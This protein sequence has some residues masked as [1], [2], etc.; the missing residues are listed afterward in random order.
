M[1][2]PG[3]DRSHLGETDR[4]T[5]RNLLKAAGAGA[6]IVPAGLGLAACGGPTTTRTLAGRPRRGGTLNV[7]LTGG[8]A[9]DTVNAGAVV[10]NPDNCRAYQL[11]N[12]PAT[13]DTN[14]QIVNVLVEEFT[15]NSDATIWTMRLRPDVIFHN[16]KSLTA[17]DLIYTL[18]RVAN[19]KAP[20]PGA[21]TLA[22]CDIANMKKLDKLTV[23]LPCKAPYAT[24]V[25]ALAGFAL[26]FSVVP[27]DYNPEHPV[28]TG[29]F[30][31]KE[32][33]PGV[34]ST[35]V[36]NGN[37]FEQPYPYFDE[38]I[39]SEF[40]DETSQVNA[41]IGGAADVA[42]SLSAASIKTVGTSGSASTIISKT[43]G[44]TPFTIRVD[45]PPFNDARVRQALRL[46]IDRPQM[47]NDVFSGYGLIGNDISSIYDPEYDHAIPQ[48]VQDIDQAKFL[49]KAAG[50][51]GLTVE[52]TTADIAQG[53]L[54]A[55]TVLKQ[56]A[57]AAGITINLRVTTSTVIYGSEYLS[58]AFAQD[59]WPYAPY[60][61]QV[62]YA[63]LPNSPYNETHFDDPKYARLYNEAAATVDNTTRTDIAHEM[64]MIDYN[65]GGWIVPYFAPNIDAYGNDI[66]GVVQSRAYPLGNFGFAQMWRS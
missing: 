38:V 25:E 15:P 41:L 1:G 2:K 62:A 4:L 7:A 37:Y 21:S 3:R 35:F 53:T 33:S 43:G 13:V 18:Q 14:A 26:N 5:R 31:F 51:E 8:A 50:R 17:D 44:C 42:A 36:R 61:P 10:T 66:H 12:S 46:V 19:P 57:M 32:F 40:P 16:G 6:L 56:Q 49:L 47:L 11:Y 59:F 22:A 39:I 24:F 9:T 27:T 60:Y 34:S 28:G 65:D 30:K 54:S 52:L 20:L 58:W 48:R 23:A 29:P 64:Q 45:V 55:A 63:F